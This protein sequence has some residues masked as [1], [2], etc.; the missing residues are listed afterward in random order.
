MTN[1]ADKDY[2][3]ISR[4]VGDKSDYL[5]TLIIELSGGVVREVYCDTQNIRVIKVDCERNS[6]RRR[7]TAPKAFA[8]M[9]GVATAFCC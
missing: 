6:A 3:W 5:Q 1:C 9:A 2:T 4:E 8:S 7:R